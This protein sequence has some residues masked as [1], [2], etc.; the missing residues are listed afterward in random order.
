MQSQTTPN[1]PTLAVSRSRASHKPSPPTKLGAIT[2]DPCGGV[3]L[4]VPSENDPSAV[5]R[6]Q[7][8]SGALCLASS[9][10]QAMLSPYSR[11]KDGTNLRLENIRVG[12]SQES[13]SPPPIE[14]PLLADD[15]DAF[16]VVLRILHL[17]FRLIPIP[18]SASGHDEEK[19]KL[20]QMAI[21]CDRYCMGHVLLYWLEIWT[22]QRFDKLGFRD[23]ARSTTTGSRWLFIAYAFGYSRLLKLV[24][25][26]LILHCHVGRSGELFLPSQ[27]HG[28]LDTNY[29]PVCHW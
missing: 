25:K 1:L 12:S 23:I 6:F 4:V 10:F 2:F 9:V 22:G 17:Q 21:I 19:Y 11:F 13:A 14:L 29:L 15:P 16:A 18:M 20:Y 26:E 8:N 28:R 7:V 3:I 27:K 24:S 5:A